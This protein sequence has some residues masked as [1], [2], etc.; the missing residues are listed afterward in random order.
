[1][2]F[3]RT[4]STTA[5]VARLAGVLVRAGT[6]AAGHQRRVYDAV[7]L[8]VLGAT[9]R[10]VG[11]AF[12]MEYG[13]LGLATAGIS[14]LLGSIA[15]YV[16]LTEIMELKFFFLPGAVAGTA[17]LALA[18]TILLGFAGTWRALSQKSA[19]LLRNE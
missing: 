5:G 3:P 6:V 8:K 14:A 18:I 9:R 1:M 17:G 10:M 4:L 12:L 19:P 11:R 13:I 15:A 7:V 2:H 16:V